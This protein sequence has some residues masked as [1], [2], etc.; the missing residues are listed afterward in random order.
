MKN[1]KERIMEKIAIE[2]WRTLMS[3]DNSS[4]LGSYDSWDGVHEY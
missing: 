4:T 1:Q 3:S 2:Q